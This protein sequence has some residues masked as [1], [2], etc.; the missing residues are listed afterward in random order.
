MIKNISEFVEVKNLR[1]DNPS[2][3]STKQCKELSCLI[4][5]DN[6]IPIGKWVFH[7]WEDKR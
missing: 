3:R 6:T 4:T 2:I 7:D 5:S 1:G